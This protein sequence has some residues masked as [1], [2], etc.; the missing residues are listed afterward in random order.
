MHKNETTRKERDKDFMFMALPQGTVIVMDE[1]E[2]LVVPLVPP[3][4]SSAAYACTVAV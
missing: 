3:V 2:V 1:E 4:E